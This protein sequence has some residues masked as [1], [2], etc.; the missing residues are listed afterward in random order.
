MPVDARRCLACG[1]FLVRRDQ[2]LWPSFRKRRCCNLS[3]AG[4]LRAR[5]IER[6][7]FERGGD[8]AAIRAPPRSFQGARSDSLAQAPSTCW[9]CG[10]PWRVYVSHFECV[11]CGRCWYANESIR[12]ALKRGRE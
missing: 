3:C 7:A 8:R 6:A 4:T 12:D 1:K 11:M 9:V 2:E 10:G 5:Q